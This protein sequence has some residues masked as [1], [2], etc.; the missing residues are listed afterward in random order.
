MGSYAGLHVKGQELIWWKNGLSPIA[1]SL[2][3]KGDIKSGTGKAG[4][5][6]IRKYCP[7]RY[8]DDFTEEDLDWEVV[9][10]VV[11]IATLRQRLSI[12]GYSKK[13]FDETIANAIAETQESLDDAEENMRAYYAKHLN[14]LKNIQDN[15]TPLSDISYELFERLGLYDELLQIWTAIQHED[16]SDTDVAV[17]DL[18][19]LVEGGWLN[20]E[21]ANSESDYLIPEGY[22]TPEV[23][24]IITEGVTDERFL[25]K[26]LK[27]IYPKLN[28]NV[29]FLDAD[30]KPERSADSAVKLIKS[31]ASAGISNRILVVL[32]NDAAGSDAIK[33]LPATLPSNI[34]VIQYPRL[35]W[36]KSYPTIGPQ[37][38]VEMDINGL[39]GSIEMYLG[40]D[41]LRDESG[42]LVRVQWQG[43][44]SRVGKYQGSLIDKVGV[45]NRFDKKD[46]QDTALWADLKYVWDYIIYELSSL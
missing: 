4:L 7:A 6:L 38:E 3:T 8:G 17:I 24:I 22:F 45:Q 18:D 19:D 10:A 11:D 37:G 15:T 35:E 44:V 40:A 31:F 2:F 34:K 41:V 26:S 28:K 12:F 5:D 43:F 13:I 20:E 30:F 1:T 46:T 39:A 9:L 27:V 14:A 21:Y 16:I 36:L 29:K 42:E 23:P 32:D 25:E 33:N